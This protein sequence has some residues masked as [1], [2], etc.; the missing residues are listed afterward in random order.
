MEKLINFLKTE[1]A[2]YDVLSLWNEFTSENYADDVVY[3]SIEEIA[4]LLDDSPIDFA[5]RVF[6]GD[7]KSWNASYF[8]LNGAGNIVGF[9]SLTDDDSP[10]DYSILSDW[11]IDNDRLEDID[12]P[13]DDDDD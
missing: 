2:D 11:L 1:V 13:D 6:Y 8:C 4:D 10:I 5:K 9:Y 3:D 7:V 12:Y